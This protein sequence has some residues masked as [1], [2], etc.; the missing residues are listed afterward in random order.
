MSCVTKLT[1]LVLA[2]AAMLVCSV[3]YSLE[4]SVSYRLQ[5][6]YRHVEQ[7]LFF[8]DNLYADYSSRQ[9]LVVSLQQQGFNAEWTGIQRLQQNDEVSYEGVLNEAYWDFSVAEFELT[10]G[11]KRISWGVGYAFR[12]LDVLLQAER[13]SF[14]SPIEEGLPLLALE[15]YTDNGAWTLLCGNALSY[16]NQTFHRSD[17]RCAARAYALIDNTELQ[18]IAYT[19]RATDYAVGA[20]FSQVRGDALELHGSLLYQARYSQ[21]MN[22]LLDSTEL[23]ARQ[24]P[25]QLRGYAD[26]YKLLLGMNYTWSSGV[27]LI[28]EA[29]HDESGYSRRQWQAL[30]DLT[31]AQKR[32]SGLS[33][34]SRQAVEGNVAASNQF[35]AQASLLED[36]LFARLSYDGENTSANIDVLYSVLDKGSVLTLGAKTEVSDNHDVSYGS[37]MFGGGSESAYQAM[38]IKYQ[39]YLSW[40]GRFTL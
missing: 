17:N 10:L 29:W 25:M 18:L 11:K 9:D 31:E 30:R 8:S 35:F 12:P 1:T 39:L 26:G 36:N 27:S 40:Q 22:Q 28:L 20:G 5:P 7:G 33:F 34:V 21:L 14:I 6:L 15:K 13:L 23:L 38:P 3:A 4:S 19:D 24:D 32:L 2:M 37:R 16:H